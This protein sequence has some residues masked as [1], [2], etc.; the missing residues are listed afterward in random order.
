[1]VFWVCFVVGQERGRSLAAR[2]RDGRVAMGG[3]ERGKEKEKEKRMGERSS[4]Y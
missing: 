3:G 4:K 1:M 2:R